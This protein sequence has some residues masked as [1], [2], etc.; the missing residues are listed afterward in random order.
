MNVARTI[1][2][3]LKEIVAYIR[4]RLTNGL[5]EGLNNKVRLITRRAY[6]FHSAEAVLAMVKLCCSDLDLGP[7][8]KSL[9]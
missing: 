4:C 8:R 6:G 1:R 7:V 2:G 5:L 9:S 3:S